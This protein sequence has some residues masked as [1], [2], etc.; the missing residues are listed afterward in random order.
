ML[1]GI[2]QDLARIA[3]QASIGNAFRTFFGGL[4]GGLFGGGA[5]APTPTPAQH[6][7][8]ASAGQPFF[9]GEAGPELFVPKSSG[10]IIPF[11]SLRGGGESTVI[12]ID[13]RGAAPGMERRIATLVG[14]AMRRTKAATI[15]EIQDA[16]LRSG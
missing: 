16:R 14:Q 6:G 15:A 12:N 11:D 7:A 5:P 4:F 1:Q 2:I 9:V 10:D 3:I 13:A 8:R